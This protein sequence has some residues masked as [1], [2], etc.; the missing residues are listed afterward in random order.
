MSTTYTIDVENHRGA[1][2]NY[3]VFM[4]PPQFSGGQQPW[5]N[6]WYTSFVPLGGTFSIT[7]GIDFHAWVGSVPTR[8]APGVVITSG[9]NLLSRLGSP[10]T[11]GST[12]DLQVIESFPTIAE[13]T[14]TATAGAYEIDSGADFTVP[15]DTYL[16]GLA[17]VD[18]RGRVAPVASVAPLN[19]MKIQISPKMK[20]FVTES[21]QVA[22]EI[23]DYGAVLRDGATIDFSSGE[24]LGKFYAR[25]VQG[26]NGGFTVTYY[27]SFDD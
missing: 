12:F 11:P 26:T 6:V 9:M 19:N 14:P 16:V 3:A 21:Q 27:D 24:G 13:I 23:V 18:H 15:N 10:S 5:M 22:G 25:V 8:P 2:T 7:T 17:K 1:N 4:E 20:F